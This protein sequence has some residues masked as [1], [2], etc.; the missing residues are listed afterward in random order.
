[1]KVSSLILVLAMVCAAQEAPREKRVDLYGDPLPEGALA[2]MGTVRFRHGLIIT[3]VALF[4]LSVTYP[5]VI[6]AIAG[7]ITG[8]VLVWLLR[9]PHLDAPG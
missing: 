3:S 1:M 5:A 7:S 6:G 2:R 4:A 9:H 8:I